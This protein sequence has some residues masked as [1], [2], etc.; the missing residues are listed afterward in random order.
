MVLWT[1]ISVFVVVVVVGLKWVIFIWYVYYLVRFIIPFILSN[2]KYFESF[3][4]S[5]FRLNY[6][7]CMKHETAV[8]SVAISRTSGDIATVCLVGKSCAAPINNCWQII[9]TK[10][11]KINT[12]R[13]CMSPYSEIVRKQP[14][15][16]FPSR[17]RIAETKL[18]RTFISLARFRHISVP[19][20]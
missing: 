4:F 7:Q 8:T 16:L 10:N 2:L 9:S 14:L 15:F 18:S 3:P 5:D 19:E 1:S 13:N 11:P 20:M 17:F 12:G 6:V